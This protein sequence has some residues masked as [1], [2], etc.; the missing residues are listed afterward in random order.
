MAK[1]N[2]SPSYKESIRVEAGKE[3][4]KYR[5]WLLENFYFQFCGFCLVSHDKLVIEHYEPEKMSPH[6]YSDDPTN[7]LLACDICNFIGKSDYHPSHLKR[8]KLKHDNSGF[9][10]VDVRN[11]N[12]ADLFGLDSEKGEFIPKGGDRARKNI[13]LMDLN[14]EFVSEKRKEYVLLLDNICNY[15]KNLTSKK[16]LFSDLIAWNWSN[17]RK[18][19]NLYFRLLKSLVKIE[20]FFLILDI[21][22]PEGIKKDLS[23]LKSRL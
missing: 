19:K 4:K 22:I 8:R 21:D 3:Y 15:K 1:L 2:L 11:E 14:R 20:L 12:V 17:R 7:L 10:V 6:R 9:L 16:V 18:L 23:K 13:N 5:A